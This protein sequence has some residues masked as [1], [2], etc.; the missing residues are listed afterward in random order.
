MT[1]EVSVG[2]DFFTNRVVWKVA[3]GRKTSFWN[4]R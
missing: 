3:N 1:L 2:E 4:E